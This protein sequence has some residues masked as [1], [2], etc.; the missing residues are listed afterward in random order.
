MSCHEVMVPVALMLPLRSIQFVWL[1][2]A[3]PS[4]WYTAPGWLVQDSKGGEATL[5]WSFRTEL[6]KLMA[7][8][9]PWLEL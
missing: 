7:V 1:K 9:I 2:F 4:T 6:V 3:F 5:I 8:K